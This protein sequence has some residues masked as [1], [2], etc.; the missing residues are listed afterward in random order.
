MLMREEATRKNN[1]VGTNKMGLGW[2]EIE[3]L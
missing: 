2:I 1:E 3:K